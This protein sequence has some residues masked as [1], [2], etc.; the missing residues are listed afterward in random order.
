MSVI[1]TY[2]STSPPQGL[3][4]THDTY[5]LRTR[6]VVCDAVPK[7]PDQDLDQSVEMEQGV[8]D[9]CK[10]GPPPSMVDSAHEVLTEEIQSLQVLTCLMSWAQGTGLK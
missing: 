1:F 8:E 6:T 9:I 2:V 5:N 3:T 4:P 7:D 10:E